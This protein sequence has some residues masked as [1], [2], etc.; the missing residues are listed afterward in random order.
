MN[1]T[2]LAIPH[3][4][5]IPERAGLMVHLRKAL[6]LEESLAE[7]DG[8]CFQVFS[9]KEHWISWYR[10]ML[11]FAELQSRIHKGVTHF[12]TLQ[13]DVV[14]SPDFWPI[15]KAMQTAWP[16]DVISLAATHSFGPE[17]ARQGRRSYRCPNIVGWGWMI[18]ISFVHEILDACN[19]G[20]LEDFVKRMPGAGEDTFTAEFLA[21]RGI[22]PRHPVPTIVD[23]L[24]VP[25]TNVGF[26]DHTH[27]RSTVTWVDYS[28]KDMTT[29]DW[30]KTQ[31]SE[32]PLDLWRRCQWC[33]CQESVVTSRATRMTLCRACVLTPFAVDLDTHDEALAAT[34]AQLRAVREDRAGAAK[35]AEESSHAKEAVALYMT[36][37]Q[38]ARIATARE[39]GLLAADE[40]AGDTSLDDVDRL[41]F[42]RAGERGQMKPLIAS[43]LTRPKA[44]T[45]T[46]ETP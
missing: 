6:H 1:T 7:V 36:W 19:E 33:G 42:T 28:P 22:V 45:Q 14:L 13:D 2:V 27:R 12:L 21:K 40:P 9:D 43:I 39:L 31:A 20:A 4:S 32:F 24:Y 34:L 15:L 10:K 11:E 44:F 35:A 41:I 16:H 17:V 46:G 18:P 3:A 37:T 26:D 38:D 8:L 5:W 25:S 30:W 23:H 29:P